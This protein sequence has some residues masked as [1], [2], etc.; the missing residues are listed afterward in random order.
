MMSLVTRLSAALGV[1]IAEGELLLAP[2]EL[3]L[4]GCMRVE[5]DRLTLDVM[6]DAEEA[7]AL[8]RALVVRRGP[9]KRPLRPVSA[10]LGR[11][12][13]RG[14]TAAGRAEMV[15]G[16]RKMVSIV[17]ASSPSPHWL[18]MVL[19]DGRVVFRDMR[20]YVKRHATG[21]LRPLR[22]PKFFSKVRARHGT[23]V[24]PGDLDIAPETLV[25]KPTVVI[26]PAPGRG[27]VLRS[28][29]APTGQRRGAG[30]PLHLQIRDVVV[31]ELGEGALRL[32]RFDLNG[33][34]ARFVSRLI[35]ADRQG[36][37][38]IARHT[39]RPASSKP[40]GRRK[41]TR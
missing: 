35:N 20:G 29:E 4:D 1:R 5:R 39:G 13:R 36:R 15:F 16:R 2:A 34:I 24:W 21:V 8:M 19:D 9:L 26:V 18:R 3:G 31:D 25:E 22:D 32:G 23:A 17:K 33:E 14:K 7:E 37:E 6:A 28:A 40:G 41:R 10:Q 30:A 11:L 27:R 12:M 38:V